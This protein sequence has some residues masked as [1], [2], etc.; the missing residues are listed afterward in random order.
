MYQFLIVAI[1]SY[2]I[3]SLFKIGDGNRK[4]SLEFAKGFLTLLMSGFYLHSGLS[5]LMASAGILAGQSRPVFSRVNGYSAEVVSL[6]IIFY[7]SPVMGIVLA[8]LFIVLKKVLKDYNQAV[9]ASCLTIPIM[10]F[11][12]FRS[13]SF[14]IISLII[15]ASLAIQFWPPF[16]EKRIKS[17][18]LYDMAI[19][20][21]VLGFL[22]L[23]YFNKYVYKGFGIQKDIIRHGP[24]HFKYVALTFDDGPDPVYTPEILDILKEKDVRATFFLIGKNVSSHPEIAQRMVEEGHLIGS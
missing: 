19:G 6:G 10:A 15:F 12:T 20:L 17:G 18:L 9:F 21:G 23:L 8:L 7:M 13:D 4:Y 3:G 11:R 2:I 5:Y 24:H 1:M 16:L 22:I 14:I